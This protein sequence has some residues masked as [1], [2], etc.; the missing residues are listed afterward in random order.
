MRPLATLC[1]EGHEQSAVHVR[2]AAQGSVYRKVRVAAVHSPWNCALPQ[3]L[4]IVAIQSQVPPVTRV[5][6]GRFP[7]NSTGAPKHADHA[8]GQTHLRRD[9]ARPGVPPLNGGGAPRPEAWK[10]CNGQDRPHQAD[11]F[12]DL[13]GEQP[14]NLMRR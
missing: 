7:A 1:V 6:P 13:Q 12:S 5:L 9:G 3:V 10:C 8:A 2:R 14:G 4:Y 11:R